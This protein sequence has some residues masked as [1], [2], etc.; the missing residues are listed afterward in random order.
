MRITSHCVMFRQFCIQSISES[1]KNQLYQD[2]F[3][4]GFSAY[5]EKNTRRIRQYYFSNFQQ[6]VSFWNIM[7]MKNQNTQI[8]EMIILSEYAR[9]H[10]VFCFTMIIVTPKIRL[11]VIRLFNSLLDLC[12]F[13]FHCRVIFVIWRT[14]F[15]GLLLLNL[16]HLYTIAIQVVRKFSTVKTLLSETS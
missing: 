12:I 10:C 8:D 5:F 4:Y 1:V 3:Q 9:N 2:V 14:Y 7:S 6:N 11:C 15:L 13:F 16:N